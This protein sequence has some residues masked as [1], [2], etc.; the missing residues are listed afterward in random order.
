MNKVFLSLI[1]LC[2]TSVALA[3]K[4]DRRLEKELQSM[5]AGFRGDIGIYVHDLTTGKQVAIQADS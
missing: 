3:Q 4:V 1:L 5:I 2:S